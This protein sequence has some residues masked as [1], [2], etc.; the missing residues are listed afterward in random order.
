MARAEFIHRWFEEVWNNKR[1]DAI[2]EM[3]AEDGIANG[4]NDENGN[5]YRGPE[6]FKKLHRAFLSA[7]PDLK[8]EV[9]DTV[10][11]GDKIAARCRV[12]GSHAG[13]GIGVAPTN[14]PVEFTGMVIVHVKDG[15]ITEAWN[16]FNF[17]EMYKQ[18]GALTLNLQ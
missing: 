4:L 7:Y 17:M 14:Q 12:T 10:V 13:H 1:E 9:V 15:K 11:E 6:G 2:E 8:I 5:P 3:F 16:E 18:V